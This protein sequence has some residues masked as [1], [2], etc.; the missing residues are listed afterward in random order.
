MMQEGGDEKEGVGTLAA[1]YADV[2]AI[3]EG[4]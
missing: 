2:M 1:L 4:L 3:G